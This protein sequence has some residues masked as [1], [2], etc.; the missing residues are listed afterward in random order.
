MKGLDAEE[1][2]RMYNTLV[3]IGIPI[4]IALSAWAYKHTTLFYKINEMLDKIVPPPVPP[5]QSHENDEKE[6]KKA[7]D[8]SPKAESAETTNSDEE[9]DRDSAPEKTP[10]PAETTEEEGCPTLCLV[11]GDEY[12]CRAERWQ[13]KANGGDLSW[14]SSD[15]FV[16]EIDEHGLLKAIRLGRTHVIC[17]GSVTYE[18]IVETDNDPWI[19]SDAYSDLIS[20]TKKEDIKRRMEKKGLTTEEDKDS[21]TIKNPSSE[22]KRISYAFGKDGRTTR[23]II[24]TEDTP[25][26]RKSFSEAMSTRMKRIE[27]KPEKEPFLWVHCEPSDD[28]LQP[29]TDKIAFMKRSASASGTLLF[30]AGEMW[31]KGAE[32][33]EVAQ[34]PQMAIRTFA[35]LLS[36]ENIPKKINAGGEPTPKEGKQEKKE[37]N[38]PIPKNTFWRDDRQQENADAQ[39]DE[40]SPEQ[41]HDETDYDDDA[42]YIAGDGEATDYYTGEQDEDETDEPAPEDSAPD[43]DD[44]P[45]LTEKKREPPPPNP[46]READ[47]KAFE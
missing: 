1:F 32:E 22:T 46:E 12:R 37:K 40:S 39:K 16:A 8:A 43:D 28:G 30:G 34:N 18:V 26:Q 41:N 23:F 33:T 15:P 13:N 2:F 38:E 6:T 44:I 4:E 36:D 11:P 9:K 17:G 3:L 27:A 21:L 10:E 45:G 29:E 31:R 7:Q 24:E 14:K 42:D 25:T 47:P 20:K 5:R 19:H 35:P